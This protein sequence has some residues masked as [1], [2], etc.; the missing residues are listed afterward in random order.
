MPTKRYDTLERIKVKARA[1]FHCEFCGSDFIVQAH[2]P[3]GDH[4]NWEMGIA[5]CAFCHSQQH[6]N[7]PKQLFFTKSHQPYWFNISAHDI[8]RVG[9]ISN[10]ITASKRQP[11]ES[12][13][14]LSRAG[15]KH[16]CISPLRLGPLAL[17]GTLTILAYRDAT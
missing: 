12:R 1:N 8:A 15:V 11:P 14:A 16:E 13:Q 6:P 4:Y 10:L 9:Q 5:L 7:V 2:A 3:S 17:A